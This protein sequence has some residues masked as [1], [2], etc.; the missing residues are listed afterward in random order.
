MGPV[1]TTKT[2]S[3]LATGHLQDS[4]R[5]FIPNGNVRVGELRTFHLVY[6]HCY[7]LHEDY[8]TTLKN[9]SFYRKGQQDAP[10]VSWMLS[11]DACPSTRFVGRTTWASI[12]ADNAY[13]P[14]PLA[15]Y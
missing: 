10:R 13:L 12:R 2:E 15:C 7:F 6:F 11:V 3:S 9:L 5:L 14:S 4:F 1:E 8:H